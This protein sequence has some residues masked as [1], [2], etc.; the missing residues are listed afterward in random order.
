MESPTGKYTANAYYRTYGG[1]AGE[2]MLWV[3]ITYHED[4]KMK[5]V[6]HSEANRNVSM[7]WKN[8]N[9]LSIVNEEPEHPG[10]N[11]SAEINVEKDTYFNGGLVWRIV[12][13]KH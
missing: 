11:K 7:E 9:T 5:I 13:N 4:N 3:E 1:A 8:E 10:S 12:N 6:Y 2:V